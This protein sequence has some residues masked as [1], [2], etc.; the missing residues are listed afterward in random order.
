MT[1]AI[2]SKSVNNFDTSGRIGEIACAYLHSCCS[3]H[4]KL[5]GVGS[6]G[7]AS[8]AHNGYFHCFGNLPHHA[9][10]HRAH[11]RPGQAA[12]H[13]AEH[14]TATL[15]IDSHAQQCVYKRHAVRA[16]GFYRFGD[17]SYGGDIG[18]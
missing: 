12:G 7:Y 4:Y 9:D 6:R 2:F 14:R 3:G 13:R 17:I 10:G 8:E 16:L 1:L 15:H 5:K 18:R 11:G